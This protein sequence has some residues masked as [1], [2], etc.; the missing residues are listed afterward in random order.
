MFYLC[1]SAVTASMRELYLIWRFINN[2]IWDTVIPCMITFIAAWVYVGRPMSEF[3]QYFFYSAVYTLLYILTF[4]IANQVNSVE[5]DRI[6]KPDRPLVQGLVTESETRRRLM[7]YNILFLVVAAFL[8][9]LPLA[10][11]WMVVTQMLCKWGCSN[12]WF[13]KNVVCISLG[14]VT[15]LAA[16]WS[17]VGD[18]SAKAWWFIIAISLWAGLGLPVQDMR[19]QTG[20]AIMG[21]KT[22]PLAV[23]DKMARVLLSAWFLVGSPLVYFCIFWSQA[24]WGEITGS[25]LLTGILIAQTLWHWGIALRLW[26]YKTPKADDQTYHWFVYLFIVTIPMICLFPH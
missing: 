18:V 25:W 12:H 14:T 7:V 17:I 3:P 11:A 16:E 20:D 4:C 5:E 22:L 9:V 26:L 8:H 19:D 23:G 1:K 24:S 21:R 6:N 10:A 2:D 13:T 15:L